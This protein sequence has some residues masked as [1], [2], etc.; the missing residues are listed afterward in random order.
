MCD[1][2]VMTLGV[3]VGTLIPDAMALTG[4][5]GRV[6]ITNPHRDDET[7]I[8]LSLNDLL[9]G[10]K[11]LVGSVYGS[12]T[13][14]TDIPLLLDLHR[15]GQLDLERLVTSTYPLEDVNRGYAD[16]KAGKNLRGVLV[17]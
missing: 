3:G 8:D 4:D 17:F 9:M 12:A 13:A 11:Q 5:C 6:V 14:S 10:E 7:S 16:L 15:T 1:V 2:V